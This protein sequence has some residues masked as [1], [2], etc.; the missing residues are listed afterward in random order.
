VIVGLTRVTEYV[1][2]HCKTGLLLQKVPIDLDI[3]CCWTVFSQSVGILLSELI[4]LLH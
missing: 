1:C 3:R 2:R 4:Q